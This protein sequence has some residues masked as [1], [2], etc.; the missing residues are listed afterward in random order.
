MYFFDVVIFVNAI[1]IA[2]LMEMAEAVFLVLFNAELLLKLYTYG[3][4]EFFMKFWNV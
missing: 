3:F 4:R 2:L 1:F